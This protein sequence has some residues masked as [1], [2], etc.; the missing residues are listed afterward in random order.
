MKYYVTADIHGFLTLFKNA[1]HDAGYY[2]DPGEK[3][4]II[5]GDIMDRGEE[6]VETQVYILQLMEQDAVILV[7]GNHVCCDHQQ[8]F[9]V[10]AVVDL[11]RDLRSF[12]ASQVKL[13]EVGLL[14]FLGL[15]LDR[16]VKVYLDTEVV[17]RNAVRAVLR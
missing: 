17:H 15:W 9:F 11:D 4:I 16:F 13:F 3:K 12:F 2:D 1:L 8:T 6:A 5:C 10:I 14:R 7:R